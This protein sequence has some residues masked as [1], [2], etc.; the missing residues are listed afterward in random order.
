M[1][2][3]KILV[4]I[5]VTILG[6][7]VI[8][9][10]ADTISAAVATAARPALALAAVVVILAIAGG[11]VSWLV[12]GSEWLRDRAANRDLITA[13]AELKRAKA[14][15]TVNLVATAAPGDQVYHVNYQADLSKAL[16]LSPFLHLNGNITAAP[17]QGDVSRWQLY[18]M[19]HAPKL[20][21]QFGGNVPLIE[22][23]PARPG[24]IEIMAK[25]DRILLIGGTGA[26]K[27]NALKH[28]VAY[29]VATGQMVSVVDPH[30][31][32]KLLGIDVIG[33][34]TN[35]EQI[36]DFFMLTMATV[37]ARY[38]AG[39]IAQ[40][41]NLGNLNQFLIVEEFLD[42]HE[43]LGDLATDFLKV[44]LIRARKAGFR[45]CLVSQNDSVE[46]LGIR[47]N[48][49]L[50][51]GAE[52][53]ELRYDLA[54]NQRA[55]VIGWGK[56]NQFECNAPPLF[57]DYPRVPPGQLANDEPP[58]FSPTERALIRAMLDN[59]QASKADIYRLA[60]VSKNSR[61]S[62]FIDEFLG[63]LTGV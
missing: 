42:I 43:Q 26:G 54:T 32:S 53:V 51:K 31:P 27:T 61:N 18:Q 57:V 59:P 13:E 45:F 29:L 60:G 52:R 17:G 49:G 3:N 8:W 58:R 40:D 44:M 35:F 19:L 5:I 28:Y 15:R 47:G 12:F 11:V 37:S 21:A 62:R 50:L 2:A 24:L 22:S 14:L 10:S 56:A 20:P 63:S 7:A 41:G 34:K 46:A 38:Q 9:V 1:N 23:G 33:A 48:A 6:L 39:Q 16:H 36:A 4:G 25:L 55:A 30:S